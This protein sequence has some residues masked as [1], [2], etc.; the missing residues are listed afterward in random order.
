[1]ISYGQALETILSAARPLGT[2]LVKIE[3]ALGYCLATSVSTPDPIPR[4]D[5]SSVDGYGVSASDTRSA[6]PDS[7]VR[8]TIAG[9]IAAGETS[10][11][12]FRRGSAVRIFTGARIPIGVDAV[13][14]REDVEESDT[15]VL[16]RTAQPGINIRRAGEEFEAGETVLAL[17]TRVTPAV[18]GLLTQLGVATV[19]V[20][21]KPSVA[22][23]ITGN[24]F[25][26]SEQPLAAGQIYDS[27]TPSL[28][29][30]LRSC[31]L[32]RIAASLIPDTPDQLRAC[33][34]EALRS[35]DVVITVGGISMGDYDYVRPVLTSLGVEQEYWQV[36]MK[37][38]KP[39]YFGTYTGDTGQRKLVLGL[40]GN[41]VSALVS[42]LLLVKPALRKMMG[43]QN[44]SPELIP[45]RLSKDVRKETGKLE[46]TRGRLTIADGAWLVEPVSRQGSHMLGGIASANCLIH[47]SPDNEQIA[48]GETVLVQRIEW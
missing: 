44:I 29:A 30:S 32:D 3:N 18:V 26:S 23:V 21:R 24:E 1:V 36:A 42:Y 9:T 5:S 15:I 41:P 8:L 22:L 33:L 39:N 10:I 25:V 28:V 48:A 20:Y 46:F 34:Q 40:P 14:M 19:E 4:F 16:T 12:L 11:E 7:P 45:A 37:P 17:G 6:S 43:E 13:I 35:Q 31:G 2:E 47:C 27:N 38:G